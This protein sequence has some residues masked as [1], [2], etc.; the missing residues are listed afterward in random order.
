MGCTNCQDNCGYNHDGTIWYTF[1]ENHESNNGG[2]N[3]D[4]GSCISWA[5]IEKLIS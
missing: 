5:E 2:T 4:S 1:I 3:Y